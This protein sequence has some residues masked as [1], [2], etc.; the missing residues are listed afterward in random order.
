MIVPVW[1]LLSY[2]GWTLMT[3]LATVGIYRWS[4][5]LTGQA[6]ITDFPADIPH[7]EEWYRRAMRAHANCVENLPVYGAIVVAIV[8]TGISSSTLD[9]LAVVLLIAR[10][11][12]TVVHIALKQT[13]VASSIRFGFFFVQIICMVAM[14]TIVI[15]NAT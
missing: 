11:F 15:T 13:T 3:L 1:V 2:A 6:K 9:L 14:G 5:I 8:A 12:Q 4:R 10:I 7:G